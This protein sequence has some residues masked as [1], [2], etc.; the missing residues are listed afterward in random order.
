MMAKVKK[1]LLSSVYL[2]VKYDKIIA[3]HKIWHN[4]D[5]HKMVEIKQ[6]I[7][8]ISTRLFTK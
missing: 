2:C 7:T 6:Y 3:L 4:K 5:S 8:L 1:K